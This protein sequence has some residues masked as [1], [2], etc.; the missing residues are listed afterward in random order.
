MTPSAT[1]THTGR[2]EAKGGYSTH[3]MQTVREVLILWSL[4]EYVVS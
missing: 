4:W 1:E 3:M 2:S